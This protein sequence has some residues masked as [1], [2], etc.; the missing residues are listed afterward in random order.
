[1]WRSRTIK[2]MLTSAVREESNNCY[3]MGVL[4][5]S[6]LMKNITCFNTFVERKVSNYTMC[7]DSDLFILLKGK[8]ESP[9]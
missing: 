4:S 8:K 9:K 2:V 3:F 5:P 1:M 7:V 6:I